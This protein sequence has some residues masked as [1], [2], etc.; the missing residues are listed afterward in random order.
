MY[1]V[2]RTGGKQYRVQPGDVIEVE[3]LGTKEDSVTFRPLL[4]A[5]DDGQTLHGSATGDYPVSAK[6][7]GDAKGD[8]VMVFKY[9]NKTGYAAK[10][11]HRQLYSMIEITSIG[12]VGAAAP[13]P[14]A[15]AEA[16]EEPAE[17]AASEETGR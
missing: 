8:K 7:L 4:V 2:I 17:V 13:S 12:S 5:T 15:P 1:A 10:N 6:L 14:E 3:H 11:G 9:R 16:A